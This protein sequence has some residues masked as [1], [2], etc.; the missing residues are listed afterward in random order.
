MGTTRDHTYARRAM[1]CIMECTME[2]DIMPGPSTYMCV[3]L[4]TR[5]VGGESGVGKA[6]GGAGVR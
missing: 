4:V 5:R 6:G 1:E 3:I 2:C